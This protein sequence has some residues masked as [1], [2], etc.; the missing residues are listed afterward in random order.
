LRICLRLF[1][2]ELRGVV[3]EKGIL[4]FPQ[5]PLKWLPVFSFR[6]RRVSSADLEEVTV[7]RAWCGLQVV[8]LE[9]P[10]GAERVLFHWRRV[11]AVPAWD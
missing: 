2:L 8:L 7:L 9:G 3:L 1:A 11:E 10:L 6:Q 4:S 5:R